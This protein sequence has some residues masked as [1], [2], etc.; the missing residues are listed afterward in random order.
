MP[1]GDSFAPESNR[2]GF[3]LDQLG[4]RVPAVIVFPHVQRDVIDH[5]VHD[6]TSLVA[7]VEHLFGLEPLTQRDAT[8]ARFD[9]LFTATSP[10][11]DAPTRLPDPAESGVPDCEVS[12]VQNIAGDLEHMPVELAGALEPAL[13]GFVHVA[14][15]RQV[16]LAA[17]VGRDVSGTIEREKDHLLSAFDG[18]RT[19]FDPVKLLRDVDRSYSRHR[20]LSQR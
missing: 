17:S 20:E 4:V 14:L 8:A 7:T 19:K 1:H 3:R 15:A 2:H 6:H 11:E 18:I 13:I 9:H 12:L 10:R 5:T 16:H